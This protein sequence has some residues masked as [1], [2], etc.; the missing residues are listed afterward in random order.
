[1]R[2]PYTPPAIV[3]EE[4]L[5]ANAGTI[6]APPIDGEIDPDL[7]GKPVGGPSRGNDDPDLPPKPVS[8]PSSPD[9]SVDPPRP[10]KP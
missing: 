3:Y 4:K 8:N 7:P 6:G 9:P 1:M 5:Q 2:K 10:P